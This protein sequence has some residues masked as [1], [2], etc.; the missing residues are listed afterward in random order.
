MKEVSDFNNKFDLS[1]LT[2]G[3]TGSADS[4]PQTG[5]TGGNNSSR[6]ANRVLCEPVFEAPNLPIN[7][8]LEGTVGEQ[9]T[10]G[11]LEQKE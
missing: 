9:L 11:E 7:P 3:A 2:S 1:L 8:L 4:R 10:I 5:G 6:P